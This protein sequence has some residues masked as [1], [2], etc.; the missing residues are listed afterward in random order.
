MQRIS[1]QRAKEKRRWLII[2]YVK[3]H[4][5]SIEANVSDNS[6]FWMVFCQIEK[7]KKKTY[8][9]FVSYGSVISVVEASGS[10][11]DY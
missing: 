7:L 8:L 3:H 6:E 2:R 10:S 1:R 5:V 9:P 4:E 11:F